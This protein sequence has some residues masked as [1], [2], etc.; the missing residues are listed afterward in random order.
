MT[1]TEPIMDG[2]KP[3]HRKSQA[4]V[5][6]LK[7]TRTLMTASLSG[8]NCSCGSLMVIVM[9]INELTAVTIRIKGICGFWKIS[10]GSTFGEFRAEVWSILKFGQKCGLFSKMCE[11]PRSVVCFQKC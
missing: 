1:K 7:P 9:A 8:N 6:S 5:L 4:P 11:F 10:A 3:W 2:G